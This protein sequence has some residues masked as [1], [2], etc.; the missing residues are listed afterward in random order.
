LANGASEAIS[1]VLHTLSE[2]DELNEGKSVGVLMPIPQ[3]PLYKAELVLAGFEPIEYCLE[4]TSSGWSLSKQ[5]LITA[6][7]GCE[8]K[9]RPIA[10]ILINPGNPAGNSLQK[11]E[12]EEILMFAYERGLCVLADEVYQ[13]NVYFKG[14][15]FTSCRRV[16]IDLGIYSSG[17]RLFSFN[18]VSKGLLGECGRRGGYL[19]CSPGIDD[20]FI[21]QLYKLSSISLSPNSQGQICISI[22]TD[23]PK[24]GDESYDLWNSER[25]EIYKSLERRDKKLHYAFNNTLKGWGCAPALG[26]MYLFPRVSLPKKFI[27]K[28][29]REGK[30]AD[31]LYAL[32]LLNS[33]GV[34]LVPG[35]GFGI[36]PKKVEESKGESHYYYLRSTFLPDEHE[37]DR[38]IDRIR[39]FHNDEFLPKYADN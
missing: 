26:S 19:E 38:F 9:V 28:A 1:R 21:F 10:L 33:T 7:K 24:P 14:N 34:C 2:V 31:T 5:Q 36:Q 4:E 29:E 16:A 35:N 3:Y 37:F 6:I 30:P 25:S 13:D 12:L 15:V 17:L 32:E 23:P 39:A 20:N 18:S 27:E 22:M 8:Q 11:S